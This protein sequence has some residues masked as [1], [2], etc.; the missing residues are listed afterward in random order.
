MQQH[1]NQGY[2]LPPRFKVLMIKPRIWMA[3]KL[4]TPDASKSLSRFWI[5][6]PR[7]SLNVEMIHC[8]SSGISSSKLPSLLFSILEYISSMMD[9][10]SLYICAHMM[11][12][13]AVIGTYTVG[14]KI[15]IISVDLNRISLPP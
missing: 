11:E 8:S 4:P 13:L 14:G 7:R 15:A 2:A 3:F 12:D 10:K 5:G 1:Q 9:E 6:I